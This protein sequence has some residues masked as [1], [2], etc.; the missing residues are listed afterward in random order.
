M[1]CVAVLYVHIGGGVVVDRV[2]VV[3]GVVITFKG[4]NI[5][6][7]VKPLDDRGTESRKII[8]RGCFMC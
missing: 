3:G 4:V 2:D 7:S 1:R 8:W 5:L 6:K